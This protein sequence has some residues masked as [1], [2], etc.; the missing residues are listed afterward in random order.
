MTG[1]DD[2]SARVDNEGSDGV[3]DVNRDPGYGDLINTV[4]YG[5]Y[6]FLQSTQLICNSCCDDER[7][8][9]VGV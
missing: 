3:I 6:F 9:I 1:V 4:W 5:V 8:F 2:K 7:I